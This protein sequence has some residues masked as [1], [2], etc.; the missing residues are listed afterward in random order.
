MFPAYIDYTPPQVKEAINKYGYDRFT[1]MNFRL[2]GIDIPDLTEKTAGQVA[3]S[4]LT[5]HFLT[6]KYLQ[7]TVDNLKEVLK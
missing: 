3:N 5:T 4:C 7:N 1:H 2:Q 6:K